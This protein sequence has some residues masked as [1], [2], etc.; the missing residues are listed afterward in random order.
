MINW[1]FWKKKNEKRKP[2]QCLCIPMINKDDLV[3]GKYY[4]IFV[5]FRSL[6]DIGFIL[7]KWNAKFN[8]FQDG[9]KLYDYETSIVLNKNPETYVL[10]Y[11]PESINV[12]DLQNLH[13]IVSKLFD[14][15][16]QSDWIWEKLLEYF[17]KRGI[18]L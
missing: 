8:C 13:E 4:N 7:A 12:L 5:Q 17:D 15:N 10:D 16:T 1:L 18:I 6:R 3:D 9:D 2:Q 14:E 11:N